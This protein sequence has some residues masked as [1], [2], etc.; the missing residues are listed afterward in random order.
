MASPAQGRQHCQLRHS[1]LQASGL[2]AL[3]APLHCA[4]RLSS[5]RS[6]H[7]TLLSL[8]QALA[9][10]LKARHRGLFIPPRPEKNPV[11]GQRAAEEFVQARRAALE[12]YLTALAAHPT[13]GSSEVCR[14]GGGLSMLLPALLCRWF[15]ERCTRVIY[16]RS[17]MGNGCAAQ[18][19][20][21]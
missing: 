4:S 15:C 6:V 3:H 5:P 9:D 21:N 7:H 2:Q 16:L 13:L 10:A 1:S 20:K 18:Q 14:G 17:S 8:Q 19:H 11:E 12:K